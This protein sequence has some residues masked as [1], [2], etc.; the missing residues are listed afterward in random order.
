MCLACDI[1][2]RYEASLLRDQAREKNEKEDEE[3]EEEMEEEDEEEEGDN[4]DN[5]M[6]P[7]DLRRQRCHYFGSN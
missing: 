6:E 4:G 1:R 5:V 2:E 7:D 3:D